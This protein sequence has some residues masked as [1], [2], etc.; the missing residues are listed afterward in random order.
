MKTTTVAGVLVAL[1]MAAGCS[2]HPVRDGQLHNEE[3]PRALDRTRLPTV[4]PQAAAKAGEN[5][6]AQQPGPGT[7]NTPPSADPTVAP[8]QARLTDEQIARITEVVDSGE[9]EQAKVAAERAS[10]AQVKRFAAHMLSQHTRSK[11]R[12]AALVQ[13][14]GLALT[15]SPTA[16]QL[17][18]EASK[19][20]DSLRDADEASFDAKYMDAQVQQHQQVAGLLDATLIPGAAS[21]E[22]KARLEEARA[23]VQSHLEEAREIRESLAGATARAGGEGEPHAAVPHAH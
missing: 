12:G 4:A 10:S 19:T 1:C 23:M 5:P 20:L 15:E 3:P 6:L 13:A 17:S 22:L 16:Q 2:E 8:S 7:V 18:S 14:E 21:P 11:A 9:V